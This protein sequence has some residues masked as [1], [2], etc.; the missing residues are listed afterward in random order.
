[1]ESIDS[2]G[3]EGG[4][5]EMGNGFAETG[6]LDQQLTA[7]LAG[8]RAFASGSDLSHEVALVR[9]RCYFLAPIGQTPSMICRSLSCAKL[10]MK[11]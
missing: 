6:A 1:M 10:S 4:L 9:K 11:R 8:K 3:D 7:G 2:L 5:R